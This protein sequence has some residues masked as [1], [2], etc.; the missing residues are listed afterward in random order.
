MNARDAWDH[1][2]SGAL[3]RI[4]RAFMATFVLVAI[5][6]ALPDT[7]QAKYASYV[8][9]ADTGEVLH[10]TNADTRN[11]PAS[12]TKMMTLYLVFERLHNKRWTMRTKLK[13]SHRAAR[14]PASKLALNF[15]K[16]LG[17]SSVLG[18]FLTILAI[19]QIISAL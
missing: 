2:Q 10:A 19:L 8:I 11:Y 13:V 14:Q 15:S 7:A 3:H 16:Y 4:R 12:L 9:D 6:I 17:V 5:L 18:K 1:A